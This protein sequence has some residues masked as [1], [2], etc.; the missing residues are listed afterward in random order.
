MRQH[1]PIDSKRIRVVMVVR[2]MRDERYPG[3]IMLEMR[4]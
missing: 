1:V 4:K 2:Q 3:Y